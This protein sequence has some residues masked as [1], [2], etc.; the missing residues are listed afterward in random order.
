MSQESKPLQD[1]KDSSNQEES[2]DVD[3][4]MLDEEDKQNSSEGGSSSSADDDESSSSSEDDEGESSDDSM[5]E[6]DE[7]YSLKSR[8][9]KSTKTNTCKKQPVKY[10]KPRYQI[11]KAGKKND[12]PTTEKKPV[13]TTKS[14]GVK[15]QGLGKKFELLK[16]LRDIEHKRSSAKMTAHKRNKVIRKPQSAK[17]P[18]ITKPSVQPV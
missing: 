11:N 7:D 12:E 2:K 18:R 10:R 5:L 9:K 13:E 16:S 6:D 8:K 15:G 17:Q 3:I 4:E 1:K 14:T